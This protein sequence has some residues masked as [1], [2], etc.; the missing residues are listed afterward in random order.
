MLVAALQLAAPSAAQEAANTE[1]TWGDCVREAV[2]NNPDLRAKRL[3]VEQY[4]YA[5]K[6]GYNSYLPKVSASHSFTRSGG[7]GVSASNRWGLSVSASEPLLDLQA[8]SSI[9]KA[10]INYEKAEADYRD[11][12]ASLRQ[13][14][15]NAFLSLQVAQ[16]QVKVDAKVLK[17]REEN[18]R[19]INLKYESGMES[20]GN[21]MYAE[22]LA[23]SA[24]ASAQKSARALDV[25]RRELL[26]AMG[27]SGY[28]AVTAKGD[29]ATPEY[30]LDTAGLKAALEKVPQIVAQQ[31]S[32]ASSQE[33]LLSAKYA[34]YPTLDANQS[35]G[36]SGRSELPSN[37]SWSMGLSLSIPLFSSGIT[38]NANNTKA[39]KAALK[40]AEENLRSLK[41]SLESQVLNAYDEFLNA[42]D[43]V[44]SGETL[45]KADEERYKESQI[46]YMAGAISFIDLETVEQTMVDAQ[47]NQL[48]YVKNA[49]TRKTAIENLLGKGLED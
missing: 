1:L 34:S 17:L 3:A 18:A 25:A 44:A 16:E 11:A 41:L 43:T 4:N 48:Q 42:R 32:L 21:K 38:Y 13:T 37:N 29:L 31:K 24:R 9:R 22:A 14:L 33:S 7:D 46:N 47:Q 40:A 35:V 2:A 23:A 27:V 49:N 20:R 36:W 28:K 10:R 39:M 12:S 30:A 45:V 5:Y 8:A 15:Y 19:L 6:A 26:T